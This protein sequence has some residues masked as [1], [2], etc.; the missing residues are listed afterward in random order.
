MIPGGSPHLL[1]PLG[2][3][4][5]QLDDLEPNGSGRP[6]CSTS[7]ITAPPVLERCQV[8]RDRRLRPDLRPQSLP[9]SDAGGCR[10]LPHHPGRLPLP[11]GDGGVS[12][13]GPLSRRREGDVALLRSIRFVKGGGGS[14]TRGHPLPSGVLNET[15]PRWLFC[16]AA[17]YSQRLDLWRA[18]FF[19]AFGTLFWNP[20]L[21]G[22]NRCRSCVAGWRRS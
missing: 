8:S 7:V 6:R 10:A 4:S 9:A 21:E 20:V 11:R 22:R 14:R 12:L 13:P 1:P 15:A 18:W 17:P 5:G 2:P 16:V 19:P 3:G